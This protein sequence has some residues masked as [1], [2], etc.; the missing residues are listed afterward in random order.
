MPNLDKSNFDRDTALTRIDEAANEHDDAREWRGRLSTNWSIGRIPNGG[1][2]AALAVRALLEHTGC[3]TPLS[4]TTHYYRPTIAD[5]EA[6]VHTMVLRKGR[7]TTHADA[8]LVQD[9]KVRVRCAGVFGSY[10]SGTLLLQ[11]PPP[12]L[13]RPDDCPARDPKA[14]G[15]SMTLLDSLEMRLHP[16]TPLRVVDGVARAQGWVRFRDGRANDALALGLFADAFPPAVLSAVPD[17]GWVPTI[18]LTTHIRSAAQ[19]GWIRGEIMTSNVHDG[20][21]VENVRLWDS[22]ET[23]VAEARQLALLR[24]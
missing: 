16:D 3:E 17:A 24:T 21:L 18:E 5:E 6:T 9:G 7:M 20:T 19:P 4:L 2:S 12:F 23:L 22:D 11:T 13:P 8:T 14:Q 1:Y 15:L 10:P